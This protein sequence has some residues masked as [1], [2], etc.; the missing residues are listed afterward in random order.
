VAF[1]QEA[2]AVTMLALEGV[3]MMKHRSG[4]VTALFLAALVV[5]TPS[6]AKV[7]VETKGYVETDVRVTLPGK[8]LEL[9]AG[10]LQF[11]ENRFFFQADLDV[12]SKV[13]ARA[14]LRTV[15]VGFSNFTGETDLT[16]RAQID[17][18]WWEMDAAFVEIRDLGLEGLDLRLGRQIVHWGKGDQF[19]PTNNLNPFDYRDPILFGQSM[20][21]NLV[22]VDYA[23]GKGVVLTGIWVPVFRSAQLPVFG[24]K[25]LS[26]FSNFQRR[27][28]DDP[29]SRQLMDFF[30]AAR[31]TP[32]ISLDPQTPSISL[33]NSMA[34]AK[35]AFKLFGTDLSVS[36]FRGF[37]N[38]PRPEVVTVAGPPANGSIPIK[39]QLGYPA[40][41]VL[42]FDAAT[43][44]KALGGLGAWVE[45]AVV[46]HDDLKTRIDTGG[47]LDTTLTEQ[48]RGAFLKLT[49]G[50]DYTF[51]KNVYLNI[52]YL[53]GFV[54]EFGSKFLNDY[55]VAGFDFKN[56]QDTILLRVFGVLNLQDGSHVW[57]PSL[58][59]KPWGA[60]EFTVGALLYGGSPGN[61]F[62]GLETGSNAFF[63]KG[64]V[65]F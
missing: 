43:S 60:S 63:L 39:V 65:S 23:P 42:G 45:G 1:A 31:V 25:S 62:G 13:S 27:Y 51:S 15:F 36:Y 38:L 33:K 20:A 59:V 56:N 9:N 54:D 37:F 64:R 18:F 49:A 5:T 16:R 40:M 28:G 12:S 50:I 55:L 34:A 7:E 41:H 29:Q 47:I 11:N 32:Q 14:A 8:A 17:P 26:D 52:Q 2:L 53:H 3:W 24:L 22:K 21:N 48:T 57:Y 19:N 58:S 44:L 35:V 6:F 46:F 30:A 10:E 61:K 4:F